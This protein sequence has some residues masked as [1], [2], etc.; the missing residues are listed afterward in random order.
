M[1]VMVMNFSGEGWALET[2]EGVIMNGDKAEHIKDAAA[3]IG[4]YCD[5]DRF[6]FVSDPDRPRE[7]LQRTHSGFFYKICGRAGD[8][9][10]IGDIA[11]MPVSCG[12]SD[13]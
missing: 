1:D 4:Q 7:G 6:A 8:K 12:F 10:G 5:I 9:S 11:S 13:D 3:V 2:E